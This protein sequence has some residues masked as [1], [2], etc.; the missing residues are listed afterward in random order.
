[1]T[2]FAGRWLTSFGSMDL[3]QNG[4]RVQGTYGGQGTNTI[5]GQLQADRFVFRYQEPHESGEGWFEQT[6]FGHFRGQY[7]ADGSEAW[8]DWTGDRE[9]NGIW[10]TS[11][12]RL[13]L[14]QEENRM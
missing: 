4:N 13:R 5:Q 12:G 7:R 11:F 2:T 14:V 6:N 8:R 1:M 3:Q 10:E 9:W